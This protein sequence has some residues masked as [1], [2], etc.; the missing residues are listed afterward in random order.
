MRRDVVGVMIVTEEIV[1]IVTKNV[2][3]VIVR[4]IVDALESVQHQKEGNDDDQDQ[5]HQV[6]HLIILYQNTYFIIIIIKTARRQRKTENEPPIRLL[7]D[8]FRKTKA[9]PCIYWLPLTSEQVFYYQKI[10]YKILN[11]NN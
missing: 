4:G 11:N 6:K 7:D 10:I 9:T 1:E 2:I 5:F 3:V 8:L